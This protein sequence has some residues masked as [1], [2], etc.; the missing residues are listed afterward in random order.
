MSFPV[1]TKERLEDFRRKFEA[2]MVLAQA[3]V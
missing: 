2:F 3:D 1:V